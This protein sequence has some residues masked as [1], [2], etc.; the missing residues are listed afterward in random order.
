MQD[1]L[2]IDLGRNENVLLLTSR[3]PTIRLLPVK[4]TRGEF[5][6]C[7][8]QDRVTTW[9]QRK[10]TVF[11]LGSI[12]IDIVPWTCSWKLERFRHFGCLVLTVTTTLL[13]PSPRNT[14]SACVRIFHCSVYWKVKTVIF[15]Y[16]IQANPGVELQLHP[17]V[18]SEGDGA[19][20]EI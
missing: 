3:G 13:N 4:L 11:E 1:S 16:V 14:S 2:V 20:G 8:L 7:V 9:P 5:C 17:C 10:R 6:W 15:A 12:R 19:N 18:A